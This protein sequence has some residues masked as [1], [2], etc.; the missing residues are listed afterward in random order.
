MGEEHPFLLTSRHQHDFEWPMYYTVD[1]DALK[2]EILFG[3]TPGA[4]LC[5][6][7]FPSEEEEKGRG[8]GMEEPF[9]STPVAFVFPNFEYIVNSAPVQNNTRVARTVSV[10]GISCKASNNL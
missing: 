9:P 4:C 5:F 3:K 8:E 2:F 7:D 1:N 6:F 10:I